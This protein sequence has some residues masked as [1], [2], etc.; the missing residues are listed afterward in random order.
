VA[1]GFR[2]HDESQPIAKGL[3]SK[4]RKLLSKT[5]QT[6]AGLRIDNF[7][8]GVL[9]QGVRYPFQL[10]PLDPEYVLVQEA[11]LEPRDEAIA[12][13]EAMWDG[14]TIVIAYR[15]AIDEIIVSSITV[16]AIADGCASQ[17]YYDAF[18]AG[19]GSLTTIRLPWDKTVSIP[20]EAELTL[21]DS[22]TCL[23]PI[24]DARA[25]EER[26]RSPMAQ[27]GLDNRTEEQLREQ[28]LLERYRGTV[29][30]GEDN[31]APAD[32]ETSSTR[33]L[34][35]YSLP[36]FSQAREWFAIAD[37]WHT[38]LMASNC[39]E[40]MRT[41]LL[42]DGKSLLRYFERQSREHVH[43]A[44]KVAASLVAQELT[45]HLQRAVYSREMGS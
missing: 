30:A 12:W 39:D 41:V 7:E 8:I 21:T 31:E 3:T 10:A 14:K 25:V 26:L 28:L 23:V 1:P 27:L 34:D 40:P 36:A 17:T 18:S 43:E 9:L 6:P 11:V 35:D 38:R 19:E 24:I 29:L 42:D 22:A 33:T 4:T 45:S 13:A 16:H 15:S 20:V 5:S 37:D 32:T 44:R 2:S